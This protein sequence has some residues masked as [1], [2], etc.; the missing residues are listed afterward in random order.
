MT[1]SFRVSFDGFR[2][3]A[4]SL[5]L[6]RLSIQTNHGLVV[7]LA[8][9]VKPV[10]A[11]VVRDLTS[12]LGLLLVKAACRPVEVDVL[13]GVHLHEGVMILK[14]HVPEG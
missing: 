1:S 3:F 2:K 11:L 12:L 7:E 9:V 8:L 10:L 5:V 14:T 13:L 6:Q 4:R